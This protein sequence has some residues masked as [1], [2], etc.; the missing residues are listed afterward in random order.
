M[1]EPIFKLAK[2][3]PDDFGGKVFWE[4]L[5][6]VGL[7]KEECPVCHR[8]AEV[9]MYQ[10]RN[11]VPHA[12][13]TEHGE[14]SCLTS[15]F[16]AE[17]KIKEP[18]KFVKFAMM[19][20]SRMSYDNIQMMAGL[21][22]DM[23]SKFLHIIE[24]CMDETIVQGMQHG[25]MML[26]GDGKVVEIDEKVLTINKYHRGRSAPKQITI[27]GRVEVDA[28]VH[29]VVDVRLRAAVRKKPEGR[30]EWADDT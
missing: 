6:A 4:N 19:Y 16:F 15:G 20:A 7:L 13:C 17:L 5:I 21:A 22:D 1:A 29:P 24:D 8:P 30:P 12:K 27:F 2:P 18:A 10:S 14:R 9:A 28:P 26:G 3:K 11:W 23:T 25:E